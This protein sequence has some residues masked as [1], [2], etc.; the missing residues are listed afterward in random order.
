MNRR[1]EVRNPHWALLALL[2]LVGVVGASAQK[3]PSAKPFE[4]FDG[5]VLSPDEWTDGDSFRVRRLPGALSYLL[6]SAPSN[7]GSYKALHI[8]IPNVPMIC[9]E[10]A[11][12]LDDPIWSGVVY[13]EPIVFLNPRDHPSA[14]FSLEEPFRESPEGIK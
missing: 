8:N 10:R 7:H 13:R 9:H 1:I 3:A 5:C 2:L 6:R 14:S 4:R 11:G 12:R